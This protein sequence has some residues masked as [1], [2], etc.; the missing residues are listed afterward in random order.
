M[1]C[2]RY[3]VLSSLIALTV[4]QV[5]AQQ[6]E[7]ATHAIPAVTATDLHVPPGFTI[8]LVAES[9][10]VERPMMAAL[11]DQGRLYV[12]D[13]AGVNLRGPELSKDPPH[14]I[15]VLEDR[16]GDGR[17]DASHVWADRLV[18]PQ[19]IL[20]HDGA[21]YCSSP[22]S[23]WRLRDTDGDGRCDERTELVT[24]FANT[25][26]ADDMHGA[27]LGLDGR[28]Y[29]CAGRF[30]HEIRR[31]GGPLIHRGTAPLILRCRPDG[32]D[33][34]IV[35]G[36]QGNAVGVAFLPSGDCF[37]SGTY[38]APDS[39]GAGLRDA[40][41]H[42]VDGAEY[43][44]RDRVLN[45][46]RRTGDLL[47]PLVH[48]GVAAA[49]DLTCYESDSFGPEF[50]GN[51]FAAM[52]NLHSVTRHQLEPRGASFVSQNE[53]FVTSTHP[54]FH[55]TDVLEDA[56]GSLLVVNTGG[57]FRIGCP[58]SQVAKPQVLGGIYR[59]RRDGAPRVEDPYGLKLDWEQPTPAALAE[60]LGDPRPAV[61]RRAVRELARCG[62]LVV[63]H[64]ASVARNGK[65]LLTRQQALWT[66]SRVDAP[67]ARAAVR[68]ALTDTDPAI[69]QVAARSAGLHRDHA[70]LDELQRIVVSAAPPVRR[71]AATALGRIGDRLAVPA[72]LA[73]LRPEERY[74]TRRPM[75]LISAL[76]AAP[77]EVRPEDRFL[78]HALIFALI[79]L[80]D[81]DATRLGL[82]DTEPAVRRGALIALDQMD[83][84][85]LALGEAL[86]RLD[87][88]DAPL[89]EAALWVIAHHPEWGAEMAPN[90]DAMLSDPSELRGD[91][92]RGLLAVFSSDAAVRAVVTEHMARTD[93]TTD[94][95]TLLLQAMAES[96]LERVPQEWAQSIRRAIADTDAV[97]Q[98]QAIATLRA[99]PPDRRPVA[100]AVS[101]TIDFREEPSGFAGTTLN[102]QFA[103]RWQGLIRIDTAGEYEFHIASDD[104]SWLSIDGQSLINNGGR[105]GVEER[106]ARVQLAAGLHPL[107]LDYQESRGS[108]EVHLSW[109]FGGAKHIVPAST[110]SH[111]TSDGS[112]APG[113]AAEF[114]QCDQI[115]DEFPDLSFTDYDAAL[116]AIV[117]S[118]STDL[119]LQVEAAAAMTPEGL[120]AE[121]T[122]FALLVGGLQADVPLTRMQSSETLGRGLWSEAQL[123]ELAEHLPSAGPLEFPKLLAAFHLGRSAE[124][125]RKLLAVL[126]QRDVWG[127]DVERSLPALFESY[128]PELREEA[129]RLLQ[130]RGGQNA[131][132]Q[133]EY[134]AGL[135]A[136]LTTGEVQRGRDVFFGKKAVCATCHA[137]QGRGGLI[138]PDLTR[139]A[140]ARSADDL[141]E[142]LV[143]PSVS[144][145]RGYEPYVVT[146]RDGLTSQGIIRRQTHDAVFMYNATRAETRIGRTAIE[147]LDAATVS[148]MP[149]GLEKQ[150]SR[151]ELADLLRFLE[152]LK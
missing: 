128:S 47:P 111:N 39:M 140:A 44:V 148:I 106:S 37:A 53:D 32:S 146:T 144:F 149:E 63:P 38:L 129:A 151:Q 55:P 1:R 108:A 93:T 41:I 46:H 54:D 14:A 27:S 117:R 133:A 64:V 33:V 19:G 115:G 124:T 99:L 78:E 24:G 120:A 147:T 26:V 75:N 138:G 35:C 119:E 116:S 69:Q 145:A 152:S 79:T 137:V 76:H 50:R 15:R 87:P 34:E 109:T 12:A 51:L 89:H 42:C 104:G 10:L 126:E 80:G 60:R 135:R 98:R 2:S 49:S 25:G 62:E 134:L 100:R 90:L 20:W 110:L 17:Y 88:S 139:I 16:D 81:R 83:D 127:A 71:E 105:H 118:E 107:R 56:D 70:A 65:S 13:S 6:A 9:P 101:A 95:K 77:A 150:L 85:R 123:M 102:D 114:F 58:T 67:A 86:V 122:A 45:E 7:P 59:V 132:V 43:P 68:N 103:V 11:D 66:L 21:V 23:F 141:L 97:V 31:P 121:G 73:G 96:P 92:L 125:A 4:A 57:W 82:V 22:P 5:A 29:W 130:S 30:P 18:F 28:I 52:F 131:A 94:T 61:S 40:L 72:V 112:V 8:E 113:L 84:G 142:A 136:D 48:L 74:L 143:F 36:S 91:E 3:C